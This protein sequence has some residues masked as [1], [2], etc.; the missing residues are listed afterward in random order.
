MFRLENDSAIVV[1]EFGFY[2]NSI[3]IIDF[4]A[5]FHLN[6]F[7]PSSSVAVCPPVVR[8]AGPAVRAAEPWILSPGEARPPHRSVVRVPPPSSS[9]RPAAPVHGHG[10]H[11][12]HGVPAD[13]S[14]VRVDRDA[15]PR[16][17]AGEL[18]VGPGGSHP[19]PAAAAGP[20]PSGP[21]AAGGRA[22]VVGLSD[23]VVAHPVPAAAAAAG[24][25]TAGHP[26][27]ACLLFLLFSSCVTP[28]CTIKLLSSDHESDPYDV[29]ERPTI[30]DPLQ[31]RFF[32]LLPLP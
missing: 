5:E 2:Q 32:G 19:P 24:V 17:P 31:L 18:A 7:Q 12:P 30:Y 9:A 4:H 8:P 6:T 10:R 26:A 27:A 22:D 15:A 11:R 13:V 20:A 29:D 23:V 28:L 3:G 21:A 16:A 25:V 1:G 14:P